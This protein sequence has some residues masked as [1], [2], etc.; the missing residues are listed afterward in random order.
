LQF[1]VAFPEPFFK[2]LLVPFSEA[3]VEAP[4][5]VEDDLGGGPGGWFKAPFEGYLDDAV[6]RTFVGG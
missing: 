4:V 2:G 3:V 6:D 1:I 5:F